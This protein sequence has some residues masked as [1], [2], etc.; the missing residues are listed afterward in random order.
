MGS[1]NMADT[2]FFSWQADTPSKTGK[3]LIERVLERAIGSI[4]SDASIQDAVRNLAVDRDT[5]GE[6]GLAPIFDTILRKIDAAAMFV[7]DL[8]F[9]GK[10]DDGRP[11]PNPNVLIEFGWALKSLT[12][13]RIIAVMNTHYGEPTSENMP[14]DLGHFRH[15]I[16][17]NCPP[18]ADDETVKREKAALGK[19]I[20][21]AIRA[22]LKSDDYQSSRPVPPAPPPFQERES[23]GSPGR[24]KA[25]DEPI[26]VLTGISQML[27]GESAIS[28]KLAPKPAIW[29]R[30][31]PTVHQNRTW[32]ITELENLATHG[33]RMFLLPL[34]RSTG[35]YSYVR[36]ENGFGSYD[37]SLS[38]KESAPDVAM[39]FTNGEVWAIDTW[40]LDAGKRE[41]RN[42]IYP[43]ERDLY[44]ALQRYADLLVQMGISPPFCWEAGMENLKG[45]KI[46]LSEQPPYNLSGPCMKDI[47]VKRGSFTPGESAAQS[48][49][50]FFEELYDACGATL[51]PEF[52]R[53]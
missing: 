9:V 24:F 10:R 27:S 11:T 35:S 22:I 28:I 31:M 32:R 1:G 36:G 13:K 5:L 8:T 42:L 39:V 45:R 33:N 14:F 18:D 29:L 49:R 4:G 19:K 43:M 37:V 7:L 21:E 12:H 51:P 26:G 23:V 25:I 50:P 30:V 41:G 17:Y 44:E 48:L 34:A 40:Y 20:E 53:D 3:N 47:V 38:D 2:I 15:P 6:P 46:P 16:C 52:D